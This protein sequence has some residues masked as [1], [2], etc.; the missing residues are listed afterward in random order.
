VRQLGPNE[1][2]NIAELAILFEATRLGIPVYRPIH[3]HGRCDCVL[4]I[5]RR[6]W[7]VQVKWARHDRDVVAVY[8][9]TNRST[10]GGYVTGVYGASELDFVAAYCADLNRSY[11]LPIGLVAG[12]TLVHLRLSPARNGQRASTTL[13]ADHEFA[14]AVA[15]LEERLAG[16]EEVRGSSPLS[17]TSTPVPDGAGVSASANAATPVHDVGAHEFRNHFGYWMERAAAGEEVRVSRHGTPFVRLV[18]TA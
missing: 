4:E 10:P 15:Q 7:R 2:G 5:G 16:S 6:L 18:P 12:K 17:S 13:A 9:R 1:K 8:L 3:E 11:L 14:G